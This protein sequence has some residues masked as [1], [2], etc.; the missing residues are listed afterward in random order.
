MLL[1]VCNH[2]I[3]K[4]NTIKMKKM[5][6]KK[7]KKKETFLDLGFFK[8]VFFFFWEVLK[9]FFV[10]EEITYANLDKILVSWV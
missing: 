6:K 3:C 1:Y 5:K 4:Y 10:V 7:K 8:A 2:F 9:R